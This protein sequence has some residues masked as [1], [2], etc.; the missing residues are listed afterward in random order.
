MRSFEWARL[1]CKWWVVELSSRRHIH[2]AAAMPRDTPEQILIRAQQAL[3]A[4][5][6]ECKRKTS[7]KEVPSEKELNDELSHESDGEIDSE[8]ERGENPIPKR[9]YM[10][11]VENEINDDEYYAFFMVLS[12]TATEVV[13]AWFFEV[14]AN[15]DEGIPPHMFRR[16]PVDARRGFWFS[17]VKETWSI[18]H[19]RKTT[20]R[21]VVNVSWPCTG[22]DEHV[23]IN[24]TGFYNP[25]M[26]NA[27]DRFCAVAMPAPEKERGQKRRRVR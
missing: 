6:D 25:S 23:E 9:V 18:E 13:I 26:P 10:T 15:P 19:F 21:P 20:I 16:V 11:L 22:W 27:N 14:D 3:H 1:S 7:P 17:S 2:N 5:F 24:V 4:L 8:S 12:V